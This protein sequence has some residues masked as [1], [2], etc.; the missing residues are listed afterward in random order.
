MAVKYPEFINLRLTEEDMEQLE[1]MSVKL[2]APRSC[3]LRR[4]LRE[5]AES[6]EVATD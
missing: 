5:L 6:L 2:H 4:A 1:A 3:V